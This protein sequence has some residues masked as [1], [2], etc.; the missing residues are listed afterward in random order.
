MAINRGVAAATGDWIVFPDSDDVWLP[1]KLKWQVRAI[2]EFAG[3]SAVCAT[4]ATYVNN[5]L[6]TKTAFQQY[7]VRCEGVIGIFSNFQKRMACAYAGV[8]MPTLLVQREA[9]HAAGGFDPSLVVSE[10]TDFLFQLA[11]ITSVSYVNRPLVEI[12]RTP[13]RTNGLMELYEKGSI[14]CETAQYRYEKWLKTCPD[15][16]VELRK[17]LRWG[18]HHTHI[19]WAN[20]HLVNGDYERARHSL[21]LAMDYG[22]SR[23]AVFKS[24]AITV[25]PGLTRSVVIWRRRGR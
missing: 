7:G 14:A 17:L 13:A 6:M 11:G 23:R 2:E 1:E 3:V 18:L 12:D 15:S 22:F 10:D 4:D 20:W 9:I 5:P 25:A 21:S 16:D 24:F 19:G 8:Y